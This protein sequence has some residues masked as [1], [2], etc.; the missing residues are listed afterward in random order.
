MQHRADDEGVRHVHNVR[1]ASLHTMPAGNTS[2][3]CATVYRRH[4]HWSLH[5][6]T[7]G[8]G[9]APPHPPTYTCVRPG[10]FPPAT[11]PK[12]P[13]I[14]HRTCIL[15][16]QDR[17]PPHPDLRNAIR[18]LPNYPRQAGPSAFQLCWQPAVTV[19][20]H[21]S[22]NPTRATR[23]VKTPACDERPRNR[24][25]HVGRSTTTNDKGLACPPAPH[26]LGCPL[27]PL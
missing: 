9:A 2:R 15:S 17:M 13:P 3:H 21:P 1:I 27:A 5:R 10:L 25:H 12:A 6:N 4:Q 19:N 18:P 8:L 14:C 24:V 20:A 26:T 7:G 16:A 23:H 11:T 22:A